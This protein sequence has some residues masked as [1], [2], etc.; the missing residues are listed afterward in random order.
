LP[1]SQARTGELR[2]SGQR[3]RR[4]NPDRR[5]VNLGRAA[6]DRRTGRDRRGGRLQRLLSDISKTLVTVQPLE[7]VLARVVDLVFDVLPADR[8]YLLLRDSWDQP[9]G[10]CPAT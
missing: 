7:Q 6:G 4:K 1:L 3:E 10:R 2:P 8:A 5:K 9:L